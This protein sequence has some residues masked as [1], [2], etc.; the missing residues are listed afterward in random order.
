MGNFCGKCGSRLDP[1]TGLCP[2]CD[3]EQQTQNGR[4]HHSVRFR[5]I[6]LA[7][8]VIIAATLGTIVGLGN[9]GIITPPSFLCVHDWQEATCT[10]M[11]SC[12]VCGATKGA[13]LGHTPGEWEETIDL[14][15][16]NLHRKRLCT[17]CGAVLES[18]DQT[19]T[20]FVGDDSFIFTPAQFRS[21]IV[22][23]IRAGS[24]DAG[25]LSCSEETGK[26]ASDPEQDDLLIYRVLYDGE[27]IASFYCYDR[28]DH[29]IKVE[30]KNNEP[31]WS[32]GFCVP[33]N[34]DD[35]YAIALNMFEAMVA[36]CD[37][38]LT[39]QERAEFTLR[40]ANWIYDGA[41]YD[42]YSSTQAKNGIIYIMSVPT[43]DDGSN[44]IYG[45][46]YA[47]TDLSD[48]KISG[49]SV[50]DG[51]QDSPADA[52]NYSAE[53]AEELLIGNWASKYILVEVDGEF[54]KLDAQNS[55]EDCITMV[56]HEDHSAELNIQS[57]SLDNEFTP[58]LCDFWNGRKI[59]WDYLFDSGDS[60][61]FLV[62]TPY[63]SMSD[64]YSYDQGSPV[65]SLLRVTL[66]KNISVLLEKQ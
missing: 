41:E 31:V 45:S 13:P 11:Q 62:D 28:T 15:H 61:Y 54:Y 53:E 30:G 25:K 18:D 22:P 12:R 3:S 19:L 65:Y 37:P 7:L 10:K 21:R 26:H 55:S 60:L 48:L 43:N 49:A 23:F 35:S 47:T 46:S 50:Y 39:K 1:Q 36:T 24:P 8:I 5:V 63:M 58:S 59:Q 33:W 38:S 57:F 9:L 34:R 40:C 20:S 2:K 52:P 16:A 17:V 66:S 42:W 27:D 29:V 6:I 14:L 44:Y 32:V 4:A 64:I 56:F 51:S